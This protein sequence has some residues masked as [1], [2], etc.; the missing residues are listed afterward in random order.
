M[1]KEIKSN[2]EIRW[3]VGIRLPVIL[4]FEHLLVGARSGTRVLARIRVLLEELPRFDN[5]QNIKMTAS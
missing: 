5:S 1:A 4:T 3:P 2:D